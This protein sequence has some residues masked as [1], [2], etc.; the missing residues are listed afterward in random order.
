M[1]NENCFKLQNTNSSLQSIQL[2]L[3]DW[4]LTTRTNIWEIN[5]EDS[6]VRVASQTELIAFQQDLASL[7]KLSQVMKAALPKVSVNIFI[8]FPLARLGLCDA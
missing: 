8:S 7:R 1:V 4:L 5:Q 3:C 6:G 2:L